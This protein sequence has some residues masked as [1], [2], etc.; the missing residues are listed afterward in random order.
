MAATQSTLQVYHRLQ[1]A[2][3][4]SKRRLAIGNDDINRI[5]E[6]KLLFV[7]I[8]HFLTSLTGNLSSKRHYTTNDRDGQSSTSSSTCDGSLGTAISKGLKRGFRIKTKICDGMG[9]TVEWPCT[10]KTTDVHSI[11][12]KRR[13]IYCVNVESWELTLDGHYIAGVVCRNRTK[14][15]FKKGWITVSILALR[16][17]F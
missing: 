11:E 16:L 7:T 3:K 10:I 8:A 17:V 15:M 13:A 5:M 6:I 9:E 12:M 4:C 1:I 14:V 2:T